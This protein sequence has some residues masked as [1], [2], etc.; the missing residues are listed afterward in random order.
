MIEEYGGFEK[1]S[2]AYRILVRQTD[3]NRTH[4]RHGRTL[5]DLKEI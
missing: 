2:N 1:K 5:E 3:R 4:A